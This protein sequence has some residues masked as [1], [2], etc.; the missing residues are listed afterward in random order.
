MSIGYV[1]IVIQD[2]IIF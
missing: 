2:N 1:K